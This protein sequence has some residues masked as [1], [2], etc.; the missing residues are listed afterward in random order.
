MRTV[1]TGT[2]S[3]IPPVIKHNREF[4]T[5]EFYTNNQEEIPNA[6]DDIIEKF[7]K[8]TGISE[9]RYASEN[10]SASDMA[11]LAAKSAIEDAGTDPET[12]DYI[13]VAHNFGNVV[14][15]TI[16][17]DAVPSLASHVKKALGI[18]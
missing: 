18:V 14:I 13:I 8:I 6:A 15:N 5:N 3:Y 11:Y 2:G 16:Q 10:M 12:I 1:I 9:R 4:A 7:Q 17:M